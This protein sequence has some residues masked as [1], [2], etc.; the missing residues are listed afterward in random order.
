MLKLLIAVDGSENSLRTV[1]HLVKNRA[2]YTASLEVFL[3]NVQVPMTG[4]NIKL[5]VKA[6]DLNAYYHDEGVA[7]LKDARTLLDAA[8]IHYSH[9]IGVGDAAKV[10]V[11]YVEAKQCDQIVLSSRGAGAISELV[12]GSVATKVISMAKVPLLLVK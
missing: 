11:Q 10:I 3:L 7:A 1:D 9:H 12:L 8:G 6:E 2:W 4:V 5:F